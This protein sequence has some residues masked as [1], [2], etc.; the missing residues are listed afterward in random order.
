MPRTRTRGT[1][2]CDGS[3]TTDKVANGAITT[4][5]L[6]NGSV[7]EEK[8]SADLR[9]RILASARPAARERFEAE[10]PADTDVA[11]PG[12]FSWSNTQ[13][14][15][16]RF[17]ITL[18]GQTLGNGETKPSGREWTD[19]YPGSSNTTMRFPFDLE[20]GSKILVVR[21]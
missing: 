10:I 14:F 5:K 15:A 12:G 6:G 11:I 7:T 16:T 18:N 20:R 19:V 13:D 2:I 4:V 1:Y 17:V 9:E 3:V 21:L 8:L